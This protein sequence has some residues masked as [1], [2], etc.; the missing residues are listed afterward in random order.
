MK[1]KIVHP[2]RDGIEIIEGHIQLTFYK[3]K[4]TIFS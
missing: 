2:M 4:K 3:K 1:T